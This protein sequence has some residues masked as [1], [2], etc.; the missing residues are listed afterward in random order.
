MA[1]CKHIEK[2]GTILLGTALM[3][4]T[5]VL[6]V[7]ASVPPV[8]RDALT[9]HLAIPK[10]Y[11]K[12]GGIYEIPGI[13]FSYYPMNLD[14]LYMIPLY[15]QNDIAA[16][17][18]HFLF[19]LLTALFIYKF[20]RENVGNL[21]GLLGALYFLT[22]PIIVKL[23]IT[24]YVDLGL[25]FFAWMCIHLILKWFSQ[26]YEIR[27]LIFSALFCGLALGTKYNAL[28]LLLIMGTM[29]PFFYSITQN[30]AL[31]QNDSAR[32][33]RNSLSGLIY[34]G[35]FILVAL[36]VFSPWMIRN[37]HWKKN[38]IYPLYN[39]WFVS[40]KHVNNGSSKTES[41]TNHF[42][43]RRKVYHESFLESV[44]IPVRIFFQGRDDTPKYFDGKLSPFLLI[45]PIFALWK[46]KKHDIFLKEIHKKVLFVFPFLFILFV[47]F[48][49]DMRIRYIAPAIPPLVV[50]SMFGLARL[51]EAASI[52][53]QKVSGILVTVVILSI[54][55][56]NINYIWAQYKYVDPGAYL[57]GKINRDDYISRYR[58]EYAVFQYAN[59]YL[60]NDAKVLCLLT[61]DRTYYLERSVWLYRGLF[62]NPPNDEFS[63]E[64]LLKRLNT[65]ATSHIIFG[66]DT[67]NKWARFALKP[68]EIEVV[69]QFFR[70]NTILL[71]QKYGY[72]LLEVKHSEPSI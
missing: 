42:Q 9:H 50:L 51:I 11:L 30:K 54:F 6:I 72:Q 28:L 39:S 45:L 57:T 46:R 1:T 41:V 49:A 38:P 2:Y 71:Y 8:S 47:L 25:I 21:Y 35:I 63:E 19:A 55:F 61:G 52:L 58:G 18:I 14:L 56:G 53:P 23:S 37:Y 64:T 10:L 7:L 26:K 32:K 66:V 34:G 44:L 40:D 24:V 43:T 68:H 33:N 20:L 59:R 3:F 29:I 31:A 62:F 36:I 13:I 15:F 12:H 67:F 17:Y 16:K 27:Y 4:T 65:H 22:I 60:A 69:K 5:V 48:T 70:N